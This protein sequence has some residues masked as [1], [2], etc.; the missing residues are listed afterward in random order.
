MCCE[1]LAYMFVYVLHAWYP[2]RQEEGI[3][4]MDSFELICR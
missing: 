1:F 4:I 3:G 2:R